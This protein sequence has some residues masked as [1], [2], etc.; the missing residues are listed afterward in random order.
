ML[1]SHHRERL[2]NAH[3]DLRSRLIAAITREYYKSGFIYEQYDAKT[4]E[5]RR[6]K[7]FTGWTALVAMLMGQ[8]PL[9]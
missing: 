7:P 2:V 1:I 9:K 6:C 4:G 3:N 8:E 5:G